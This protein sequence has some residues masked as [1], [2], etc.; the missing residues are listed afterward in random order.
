MLDVV[1][2]RG[3]CGEDADRSG[4]CAFNKGFRRNVRAGR[5]GA[6]APCP[7]SPTFDGICSSCLLSSRGA[8]G[9]SR[10]SNMT[11][12]LSISTDGMSISS[13]GALGR[14]EEFNALCFSLSWS[15][16]CR[17]VK[18]SSELLVASCGDEVRAAANEA[19]SPS[20]LASN[21][22]MPRCIEGVREYC[23]ETDLREGLKS[24]KGVCCD[25]G[26]GPGLDGGDFGRVIGT[27][28]CGGC[29]L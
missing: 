1:C 6:S 29:S 28:S 5:L 26:V 3:R 24:G 16:R 7:S 11:L 27:A 19:L 10:S 17:A 18:M 23:S 13:R 21:L 2:G 15:R 8:G 25:V 9:S 20:A 22:A 4:W 12:N 14:G